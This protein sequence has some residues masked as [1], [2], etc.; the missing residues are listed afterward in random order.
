MRPDTREHK[1][2]GVPYIVNSPERTSSS[3]TRP[4]GRTGDTTH[5]LKSKVKKEPQGLSTGKHKSVSRSSVTF[6]IL[7]DFKPGSTE[8]TLLKDRLMK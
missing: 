6:I 8:R 2:E 3:L 4:R 5:P 7:E 1:G